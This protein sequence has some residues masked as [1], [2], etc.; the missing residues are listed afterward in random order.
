MFT[1]RI[2]TN[3]IFF[4][5]MFYVEVKIKESLKD[6]LKSSQSSRNICW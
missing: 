1:K 5:P 3:M 6:A 4:V 2:I